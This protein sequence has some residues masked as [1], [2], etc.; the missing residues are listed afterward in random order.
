[1]KQQE[2]GSQ[3]L[4]FYSVKIH[5]CVLTQ[6]SDV[7]CVFPSSVHSVAEVELQ[8]QGSCTFNHVLLIM[9]A[10]GT[11]LK[12]CVSESNYMLKMTHEA[13]CFGYLL[14]PLLV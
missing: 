7:L 4:M 5:F 10:V 6:R 9:S 3:G 13:V 8:S 12:V 14:S 2:T 11:G 1:M